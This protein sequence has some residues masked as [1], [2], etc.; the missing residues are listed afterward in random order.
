MGGLFAGRCLPNVRNLARS[1]FVCYVP[2]CGASQIT[3]LA[4][5]KHTMY[6]VLL[7]ICLL[8]LSACAAN[9]TTTPPSGA[10]VQAVPEVASATLAA[11]SAPASPTAAAATAS[12]GS[13]ATTAFP[14][15]SA[16]QAALTQATAM[17]ANGGAMST[18]APLGGSVQLGTAH[19]LAPAATLAVTPLATGASSSASAAWKTFVAK[20][21]TVA[22]DY[23]GDWAVGQAGETIR[24]AGPAG[25]A[26]ELARVDTGGLTPEQYLA[27]ADQPNVA[28]KTGTTGQGLAVR[29]CQDTL[30]GSIQAYITV[31]PSTGAPF[32]VTLATGRRTDDPAVFT[33]MLDSVHAARSQ[34]IATQILGAC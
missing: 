6:R 28:C 4:Q 31:K 29:T 1:R 12:P 7:V 13:A 14:V 19:P 15:P 17:P 32:L 3:P 27:N 11:T 26:I 33:R 24:F 16:T 8:A 20:G 34:A 21:L 25:Q 23:P 10:P 30:A 2:G 22:V 18:L 5:R 9:I